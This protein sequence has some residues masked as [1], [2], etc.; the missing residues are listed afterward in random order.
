MAVSSISCNWPHECEVRPTNNCFTFIGLRDE[1]EEEEDEEIDDEADKNAKEE[2]KTHWG[3]K[4]NQCEQIFPFKSQF[5]RHYRSS[6]DKKPIYTCS[7]C[8]KTMEK[9][10]TFRSHCYRHVTEGRYR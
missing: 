4:C 9:Y 6:Y 8:N 2:W 1:G 7:Y 10:S 3:I 5:D